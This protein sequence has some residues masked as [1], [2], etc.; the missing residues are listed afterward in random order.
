MRLP[1][2]YEEGSMGTPVIY[3]IV[4]VSAFVLIILAVV[5]AS[6]G[7]RGNSG[8]QKADIAKASASP[9]P[10]EELTF[11]EGQEDIETLYREHKLRA[12]D[13][14]FWNMY[15][16]ENAVVEA[17]PTVSPSPEPSHEPTE[18]E[19]AADGKHIK[20]IHR[21]GEE[22]WVEI[23]EEIPLYTYD[24]TNLQISGGK[25]SYYQDGEKNSWLGIELSQSSGKVDFAAIKEAGV[26]FVMLKLGSRG[27]ESGLISLDEKFVSNITGAHEAGLEVGVVFF[28]QAVNVK[29][30][31]EEAEFVASN[32][33]PYQISYPVAFDMEYIINDNARIDSLDVDEKTQ[34]AEAFMSTI[35]KEG[36]RP[37]LY[38]NTNW[39]LGELIPDMLL[40]EYDVWLNDQSAV[41]EYP[42]QFKMWRYASQQ[43]VPGVENETAYTI[44][45]IDYTRK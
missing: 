39:I 38:G 33:I 34:I 10:A 35:E 9:S 42:Y 19:M 12:E 36:Y 5:F 17:V 26:D 43:Q 16:D 1:N 25:M 15:Q 20:V 37:I 28:S 24:F 4:A 3:T 45:F 21:D 31:V 7:G 8:K 44:S 6:N 29:E 40:L 32:L 11:A 22:E 23:S 2:D 27:Y 41:P 13:L 18:E 30:A 14:D